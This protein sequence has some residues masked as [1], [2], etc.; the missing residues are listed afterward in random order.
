MVEVVLPRLN[1]TRCNGCGLCV[2]ICPGAVV[3]LQQRF[4]VFVNPAACTYCGVCEELCPTAALA[5]VYEIYRTPGKRS[6]T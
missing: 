6:T 2:E 1:R 5:L 4:P 3:L